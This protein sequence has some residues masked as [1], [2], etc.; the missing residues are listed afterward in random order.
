M[1]GNHSRLQDFLRPMKSKLGIITT[2]NCN[3]TRTFG[4][5]L[6]EELSTRVYLLTLV[7]RKTNVYY[8]LQNVIFLQLHGRLQQ[9]SFFLKTLNSYNILLRILG[10]SLPILMK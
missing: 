6:I 9:R 8:S 2:H 10:K 5:L 3:T 4:M 1:L 7:Y